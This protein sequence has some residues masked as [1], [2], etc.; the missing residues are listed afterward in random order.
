M[1]PNEWLLVWGNSSLLE[2]SYFVLND[3]TEF[4]IDKEI[5]KNF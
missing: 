4:Y 1:H 5:G 2:P 3:G